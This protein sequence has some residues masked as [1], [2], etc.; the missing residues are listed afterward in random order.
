MQ[1]DLKVFVAESHLVVLHSFVNWLQNNSASCTVPTSSIQLAASSPQTS[2]TSRSWWLCQKPNQPKNDL[3]FWPTCFRGI[4]QQMTPS[5]G[6]TELF[7][8]ALS[9]GA[10]QWRASSL[11]LSSPCKDFFFPFQLIAAFPLTYTG[12]EPNPSVSFKKIYSSAEAA[13]RQIGCPC[14]CESLSRQTNSHHALN[15][16]PLIPQPPSR[17]LFLHIDTVIGNWNTKIRQKRLRHHLGWSWKKMQEQISP[18]VFL[19]MCTRRSQLRCGAP[20][21]QGTDC[22]PLHLGK[23]QCQSLHLQGHLKSH[24]LILRP[25]T[26]LRNSR[27]WWAKGVQDE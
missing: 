18:S 15:N 25:V 16:P 14:P 9:N 27:T 8:W 17:F 26:L 22:A 20:E 2:C 24:S 11:T 5:R 7:V 13:S 12:A 10:L 1:W 23:P 6:F 4:K 3:F 21:S 19:R